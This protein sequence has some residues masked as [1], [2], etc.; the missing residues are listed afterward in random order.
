MDKTHAHSVLSLLLRLNE[1][2]QRRNPSHGGPKGHGPQHLSQSGV[3]GVVLIDSGS[4]K[5]L[6]PYKFRK[7]KW[8]KNEKYLRRSWN[9]QRNN[10]TPASI[11]VESIMEH[12]YVSWH[13]LWGQ[14]DLT[15]VQE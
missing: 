4:P 5:I 8:L 13:P 9:I 15:L 12:I 7:I 6:T 14:L 2:E 11:A 3:G 1:K 10:T